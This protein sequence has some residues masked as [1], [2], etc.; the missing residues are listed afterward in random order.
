KFA[1][2]KIF[3]V[4]EDAVFAHTIYGAEYADRLWGLP[5]AVTSTFPSLDSSATMVCLTRQKAGRLFGNGISRY[6]DSADP[7]WNN[8]NTSCILEEHEIQCY[9]RRLSKDEFYQQL[10]ADRDRIMKSCIRSARLQTQ[11]HP[12]D[13]SLLRACLCSAREEFENRLQASILQCVRSSSYNTQKI[14]RNQQQ[15][16]EQNSRQPVIGSAGTD[17]RASSAQTQFRISSPQIPVIPA[18]PVTIVQGEYFKKTF[19]S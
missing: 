10:I 3:A 6:I 11:C 7:R 1:I 17:R 13:G 18:S 4:L 19:F 5:Q 15:Q 12:G 14:H 9:A 16:H 2:S 8:L